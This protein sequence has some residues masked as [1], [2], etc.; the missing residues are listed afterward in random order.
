MH[1][2]IYFML[3]RFL[4]KPY[5]L[6]TVLDLENLLQSN[7]IISKIK[8]LACKSDKPSLKMQRGWQILNTIRWLSGRTPIISWFVPSIGASSS[9]QNYLNA[10]QKN[11]QLPAELNNKDKLRGASGLI[12]LNVNKNQIFD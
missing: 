2:R 3:K 9:P 11:T 4:F 7:F 10:T 8:T 5:N 6:T 12:S 1:R